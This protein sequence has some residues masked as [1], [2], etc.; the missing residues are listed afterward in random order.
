MTVKRG[1]GVTLWR[2]IQEAVEGEIASGALKPGDRLPTEYELAER[3]RV[4]RHTVRRALSGLEEKALVRIEQ[5]RG[6]F[7]QENVIDYAVKKRTRF[8]ENLSRQARTASN[9][10]IDTW[11]EPASAAIAEA[12]SVKDG[13]PVAVIRAVGEVDGRPISNADHYFSADRLPAIADAFRR[14]HSITKSLKELGVSD[15]IRKVTRVTARMPTADEAKILQ[16]PR[17]RPILVAESVNVTPDGQP[18]EFGITR[19]AGD[20]VQ[21]LFEP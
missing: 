16:Q 15:Y 12:L 1:T 2:Q 7:V 9:R 17:T 6:T 18:V 13:T 3:F 11:T 20:R 19:F 10:L 14:T 8:S 4:N 5:G 21:I